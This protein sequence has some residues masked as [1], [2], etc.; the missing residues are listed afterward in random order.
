MTQTRTTDVDVVVIGAGHNGLVTA[1]YLAR[2]GMSTLL[3]EARDQVGG[4]AASEQFA[5]ATVNICSCDH[6]T[7][8]TTPVMRELGLAEHGLEYID[9]DPAQHNMTWDS[10]AAGLGWTSHHDL[11]ATLEQIA[12]VAPGDVD[13]YRRYAKAAIPA[14]RMIFEAAAEPPSIT[15]LTRLALRRRLAGVP[16][17]LRWSRRSAADVLREYFD[18]ELI[19]GPG[20]M[21][22]PM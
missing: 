9:V 6:L 21:S 7:F 1:A 5:G 11:D 15:G 18:S 3:V 20:A 8:R 4:T 17:L 16:A 12:A 22:G 10:A 13:G 2:E 19:R 14:V